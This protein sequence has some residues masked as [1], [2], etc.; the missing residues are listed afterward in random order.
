MGHLIKAMSF[1]EDIFELKICTHI[2]RDLVHLNVIEIIQRVNSFDHPSLRW[3]DA[4][5]VLIRTKI[6]THEYEFTFF[7][8]NYI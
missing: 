4:K 5:L 3:E 7:F 6:V 2:L 1:K 8:A